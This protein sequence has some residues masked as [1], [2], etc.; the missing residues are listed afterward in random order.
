MFGFSK[1]EKRRIEFDHDKKIIKVNELFTPSQLAGLIQKE[2][3]LEK[4]VGTAPYK[5]KQC[6]QDEGALI[7]IEL[8][9]GW[10]FNKKTVALYKQKDNR[11]YRNFRHSSEK[12]IGN[13]FRRV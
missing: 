13:H 6:E 1:K 5:L 8:L 2:W 3:L 4:R 11:R 7:D 12:V 10:S 9:D